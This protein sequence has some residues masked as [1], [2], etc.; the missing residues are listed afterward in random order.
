[1]ENEVIDINLEAIARGVAV[2]F[3]EDQM[4]GKFPY[5][6]HLDNT[7]SILRQFNFNESDLIAAALLHD[8]F[9]DTKATPKDLLNAGISQKII[10]IVESVTDYKGIDNRRER[11]LATYHKITRNPNAIII[12]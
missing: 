7:A 3:H 4:Y 11:K 8:T 9:E 1:M 2:M 6:Y 5:I 12:K 10:D